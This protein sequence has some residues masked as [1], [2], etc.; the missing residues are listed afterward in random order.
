M[1]E[2]TYIVQLNK[3]ANTVDLILKS[4]LELLYSHG[5]SIM[6]K[7]QLRGCSYENSFS[8]AVPLNRENR[9]Y[10]LA[11]ICEL[12]HCWARFILLGY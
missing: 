10:S 6:K 2:V 1:I 8:V 5:I 4:S 11:F 12:Y 7:W 3:P 9:Y